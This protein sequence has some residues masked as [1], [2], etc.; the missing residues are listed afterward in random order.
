M[1]RHY[2]LPAVLGGARIGF[3]ATG[4][5]KDTV[6]ERDPQSRGSFRRRL[7]C[8]LF[9]NLVVVHC[10]FVLACS[11]GFLLT[12]LRAFLP[13]IYV[14]SVYPLTK[15]VSESTATD[16][17]LLAHAT[18]R[19]CLVYLL[20]RIGWPPLLWYSTFVG[21]CIPIQYAFFTPTKMR[22]EELLVRD[23]K[24]DVLYPRGDTLVEERTKGFG[25]LRDHTV[26]LITLYSFFTLVVSWSL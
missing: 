11:A 22:E 13:D 25:R 16:A 2:V 23:N 17:T 26:V 7:R 4:S 1:C 20:T 14:V 12:V 21:M 5:L 6:N 9:R 3:S 24:T 15:W 8:M 18:T 19:A 10:V